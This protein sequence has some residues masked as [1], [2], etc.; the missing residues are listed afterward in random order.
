VA[1]AAIGAAAVITTIVYF[2][3]PKQKTIEGCVESAN[4]SSMLTDDKDHRT[5]ALLSDTIAIKPG[6]RLKLKGKKKKDQSET[7]HFQV[8]KLV[9]DE[10]PCGM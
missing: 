4:G 7:W 9:K 1:G 10:G 3:I 6:Q 5:Y 2:S 8:K